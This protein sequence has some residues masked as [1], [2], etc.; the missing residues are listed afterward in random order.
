MVHSSDL[1]N[2]KGWSPMT[3]SILEGKSEITNT[4]FEAVDA[5]DAGNIYMQNQIKFEGHE[6]LSEL[7]Q[8]QGEKINE[9]IL[10]FVDK[11]PSVDG[12][13]QSGEESFYK[14]RSDEDSELD[15]EK[16]LAEQFNLLRVVDNEKY[17]A[18]FEYKGKKYI[19]KIYKE[20]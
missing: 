16:T 8:K 4:L 3:W 14:K 15:T 5:V 11:Y 9:L 19:L 17:P 1:P 13:P 7:H 18:F 10:D 12:K 6:L 2:G 20:E